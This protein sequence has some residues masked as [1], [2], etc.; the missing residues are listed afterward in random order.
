MDPATG[1]IE[2]F[3]DTKPAQDGL[4][5]NPVESVFKDKEGMLWVGQTGG[6]Y[7]INPVRKSHRKF[8]IDAANPDSLS[9]SNVMF[10]RQTDDQH[11]WIGTWGGGLN[12]YNFKTK[13]FRRFQHDPSDPKTL[14]D[15]KLVQM[16]TDHQGILWFGTHDGGLDRFDK[17]TETFT[18]YLD[19]ESIFQ[20]YEDSSDRFW[21]TTV[22]NGFFLLDRN[23][24]K[25]IHYTTE[26]GLP[27]NVVP[28]IMQDKQGLLW[29]AT[30]GGVARFNPETKT[31]IT[32]DEADGM[33][34]YPVIQQAVI[35][36]MDGRMFIGGPKGVTA[37]NPQDFKPNPNS[38][39]TAITGLHVFEDAFSLP[40]N[41]EEQITL[42]YNQ[43]EL[44]F[45][46]AGLHFA[47]P[48]RNRYTY[49]LEG[50]DKNWIDAGTARSA[51]YTNLGPGTYTFRVKS[52]NSDGVWDEKGTSLTI[53]ILP[54]WWRTT[55][56][57]I[58]YALLGMAFIVILNRFLRRR[59]V[60]KE[61]ER[62]RELE[63]EQAREALQQ[64]SL[65]RV[66]AEI[67]SMRTA[68]D[69]ERITPLIWRE[70]KALEVP[71][72]RCGVFIVDEA[73][74][75]VGVFLTTPDGKALGVLHLAFDS[76]DLTSNTVK[77]WKNKQ[78]YKEH[79]NKEDFINW[80]KSM[81][82][83]GQV[84][85]AETYQ[86]SSQPPESLYLHFVPF[87]QGMLYVGNVDPLDEEKLELT[88]T[89]A[90]AFSIAY[91]RYEDFKNLEE[92]K[93]AVEV[94]LSE[95]KSAQSQLVHSEKMA[96]LGELTA[97]IAHEIKNPLNFIN[98]FSEIS[99]ELLDEMKADLQNKNEEEVADLIENLKQNLEKINQH[100]KRADSIV[101]GMLL[102]SRGTSGEKALTDI[103]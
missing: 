20:I 3:S 39:V 42:K 77:H 27:N 58:I 81:M 10:I 33:N 69:L 73:N 70:L 96:S 59:L 48:S 63:L 46:Y 22:T 71:F 1:N 6:L 62:T 90:E 15:N 74:K 72:I 83:L 78:V 25:T 82:E 31:F 32:Y 100:G 2:R 92:A 67:A 4:W 26:D 95:L 52:S 18:T 65:D 29:L 54:P 16:Y 53:K 45:D 17:K 102:H 19:G 47:N 97:G 56:A 8:T 94:T 35:K 37:I 89:L 80:T 49:R 60:A 99:N 43:N 93:A 11:L 41:R 91:A 68:K 21:V 50:Y 5:G 76:N 36:G 103:N 101:K 86:G 7:R 12:L 44:T 98:N 79:W 61:L 9:N 40:V 34:N 24:G 57:Y 51:K 55:A 30:S 88:K 28:G 23:T 64:A 14:S 87:E 38:P 85:N 84:Q 75:S 13:R 66:R